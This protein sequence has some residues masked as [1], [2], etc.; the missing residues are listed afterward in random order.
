[1]NSVLFVTWDGGGNVPPAL[2]IAAE[3]SRRGN[4]VRF[5]GH[6]SQRQAI[7]A[8]GFAAEAFRHAKPWS[9]LDARSGM[10][11]P[12]G[13]AAVFTDRGIGDDLVASVKRERTDRVIIDGLLIGAL[14]GARRAGIG[15]TALVHTLYG[16][17][18][19]TLT[20]GPLALIARG[21]R[22]NPAQLY[23]AA[24]HILAVT[25]EELDFGPHDGVD[26][27]GPVLPKPVLPKPVLP[28]AVLPESVL[29]EAS[30]PQPAGLGV[31]GD[32]H[33]ASTPVVLVSLSTT[34]IEGQRETLQRILN[35]LSRMPVHAIV[36]TGPAVD[37]TGLRAP[38]NAEVHQYVPH[39]QLMSTAS[40]VITH[41]GHATTMLALSHD[42]PLLIMPMNRAFDQPVIGR[43]IAD[44][45]AGLTIDKKATEAEIRG[46][47][48]R[49]LP[50][51]SPYRQA[52]ARL[53][54]RI[55]SRN[56]AVAAADLIETDVPA[57]QV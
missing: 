9:V 17:M 2:G 24:D 25:L 48:E 28:E 6:P 34:Y 37:P 3:L 1:M 15:Y 41:G 7:E 22:F 20:R 56:G 43:V 23:Q 11:A 26:Y 38:E 35:A 54:A 19:N 50:D 14:D 39:D 10:T 52:A 32:A 21:K 55:R 47:V 44:Q 49:L 30:L 8:A 45:N 42:L 57:R 40:L 33:S 29:P 4:A 16:V 36:T 27:T 53:G 46:A 18:H 5:L 31:R 12:L 13:Y 51:P